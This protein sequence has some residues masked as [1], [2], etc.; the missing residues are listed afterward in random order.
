M[1]ED[2]E[3]EAGR[4]AAAI[5]DSKEEPDE[6]PAPRRALHANAEGAHH[7]HN[8]GSVFGVPASPDKA[9]GT[10]EDVAAGPQRLGVFDDAKRSDAEEEAGPG[11]AGVNEEGLADV[12]AP[13]RA[14]DAA[15]GLAAFDD[16]KGTNK[17]DAEEAAAS[18]AAGVSEEGLADGTA[19]RRAQDDDELPAEGA[20]HHHRGGAR[21][22]AAAL[23]ALGA[24]AMVAIGAAWAPYAV[25]ASEEV[26]VLILVLILVVIMH[27]F[28]AVVVVL[29]D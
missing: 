23:F 11:A 26:A 29:C 5:G 19:P 12:K 16:A 20:G 9:K 4:G 28:A 2:A 7:R 15:G 25:G 17:K 22:G 6:G 24:A 1:L 27:A 21:L 14:Q 10:E 8:E 13:R 18:G 3:Q